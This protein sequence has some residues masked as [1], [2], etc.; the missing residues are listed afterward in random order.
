MRHSFFMSF[1][2]IIPLSFQVFQPFLHFGALGADFVGKAATED[3]LIEVTAIQPISIVRF[4]GMIGYYKKGTYLDRKKIQKIIS[5]RRAKHLLIESDRP[6][7]I[8]IDGEL[9]HG[10][11]FEIENLRRAL[12]FAVPSVE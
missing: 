1:G 5:Y 3:G 12:R 4:A 8:G 7:Y 2:M 10:N 11:H 6:F 9:L